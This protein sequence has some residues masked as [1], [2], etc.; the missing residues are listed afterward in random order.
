MIYI[1][2]FFSALIVIGLTG[3]GNQF[4]EC[5]QKQQEEYRV[6]HPNAAYSEASRQR[7]SFEAMC[8][9]LKDK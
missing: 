9:S 3:C 1:F 8:S 2:P 7:S 4:E 6:S 5:I